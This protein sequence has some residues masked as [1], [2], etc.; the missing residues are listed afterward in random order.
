MC[1]AKIQRHAKEE[2]I[3]K[4]MQTQFRV[5]PTLNTVPTL[6]VRLSVLSG[7]LVVF[8]VLVVVVVAAV[9]EVYEFR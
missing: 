7:A 4:N 9:G 3:I 5:K 6:R 2:N 8:Q 1:K